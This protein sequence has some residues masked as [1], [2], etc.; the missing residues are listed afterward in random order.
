MP[1]S[2]S[3]PQPTPGQP[4]RPQRINR[5]MVELGC[6]RRFSAVNWPLALLQ[7]AR[8]WSRA[9]KPRIE[10]RGEGAHLSEHLAHNSGAQTGND[11]SAADLLR[12]FRLLP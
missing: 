8:G 11:E 6:Q 1:S 10:T 2:V 5:T 9:Y 4:V 12:G 7:L 3:A